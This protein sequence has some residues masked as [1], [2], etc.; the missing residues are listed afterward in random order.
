MHEFTITPLPPERRHRRLVVALVLLLGLTAGV[1]LGRAWPTT[2]A[3][4]PTGG[5][6]PSASPT[7][8]TPAPRS[9]SSAQPSASGPALCDKVQVKKFFSIKINDSVHHP[10]LTTRHRELGGGI[11]GCRWEDP[12]KVMS[13]IVGPAPI[14][15]PWAV[16]DEAWTQ[17]APYGC[18]EK[19]PGARPCTSIMWGSGSSSTR[20]AAWTTGDG[21]RQCVIEATGLNWDEKRHAY[22]DYELWDTCAR[23]I[24]KPS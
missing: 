15:R 9:T 22:Q 10:E 3:T 8:A 4:M 6:P 2:T 17:P 13:L 24:G 23:L 5:S 19:A 7:P 16:I 18:Q 12:G 11:T 20:L 14:A 21:E 1:A